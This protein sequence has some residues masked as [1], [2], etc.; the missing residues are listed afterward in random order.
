MSASGNFSKAR[1]RRPRSKQVLVILNNRIEIV[2]L[3][4]EETHPPVGDLADD[5]LNLAVVRW[6]GL[7]VLVPLECVIFLGKLPPEPQWMREARAK[8]AKQLI[9]TFRSGL[10][11]ATRAARHEDRES[12]RAARKH[13]RSTKQK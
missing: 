8:I 7:E 9:S 2:E 1:T 5:P 13:G 11:R 10:K 4:R 12:R 3:I 6:L